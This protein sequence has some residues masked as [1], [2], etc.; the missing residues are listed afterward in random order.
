MSVLIYSLDNEKSDSQWNGQIKPGVLEFI[1]DMVCPISTVLFIRV[2]I[3]FD[4]SCESI[5]DIRQPE[6][7]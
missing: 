5:S 2:N 4:L 6:G 7:K 3:V 1:C